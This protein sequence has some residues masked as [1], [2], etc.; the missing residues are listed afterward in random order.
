MNHALIHLHI[1]TQ[2]YGQPPFFK[3]SPISPPLHQ[4]GQFSS[5]SPHAYTALLNLL[6][7]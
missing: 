7:S 2:P 6:S 5:S 4:Q 1:L 3:G